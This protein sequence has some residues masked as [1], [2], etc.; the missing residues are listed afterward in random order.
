MDVIFG[1]AICPVGKTWDFE[2]L[3]FSV[4]QL[5]LLYNGLFIVV[6]PL[7]SIGE[8]NLWYAKCL[9]RTVPGTLLDL[10]V[11]WLREVGKQPESEDTVREQFYMGAH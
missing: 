5:L 8:M 1:E 3:N 7:W 10:K 2:Q 11:P 4:P 6:T 9:C